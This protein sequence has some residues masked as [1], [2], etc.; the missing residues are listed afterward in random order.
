MERLDYEHKEGI[1]TIDILKEQNQDG[2][3]E[4]EELRRTIL[5]LRSVQ[6]DPSAEDREKRKQEKMALMMSKFD[7]V[8]IINCWLDI[9]LSETQSAF[10]EKDEELRQVLVKLEAV[11]S[12]T[13]LDGLNVD[14]ITA[15]RRQLAEGQSLLRDSIDK[16]R[17]SQ[18]EQEITIRRRDELEARLATL[19]TEYEELLEKTIHD[20]ETS[21]VDLAESMT[22]LKVYIETQSK[23]GWLTLLA[24]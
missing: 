1:I 11:D 20:E 6:R 17:Q 19:E 21:N 16:L 5:D 15:V 13:G 22:D 23:A 14:D 3:N 2:K 8:S 4:L 7:T 9:P 10:T 18:E 12:T 24:E